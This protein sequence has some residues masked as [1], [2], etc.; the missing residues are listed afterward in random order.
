[1][2]HSLPIPELRA[3]LAL[4]RL[5]DTGSARVR[6]L[7]ARHGS[8]QAAAAMLRVA[9]REAR[10]D[11]DLRWL[12]AERHHLLPFTSADY[13]PLL[14][15]VADAPALLYVRGDPA[16]LWRAQVAVVG[17]RAASA[18]GVANA[19]KFAAA[20]SNAGITVTS[21][22]ATGIDGAAHSAALDAGGNTIAVCGTGLDVVYPRRH[23]ELA[24]RIAERDALVSELP[25]G[26]P[27]RPDHFPRRNRIISGLSLGTLVVE[28]NFESG[29][30]ITARLAA[31][32][33]REVFAIPGSIH[34]P[35]SRGCHRLLRQGAVLVESIDDVLAELGS[36]ARAL[37]DDIAARLHAAG[38]LAAPT[39]G[40]RAAR[41]PGSAP[42]PPRDEV[43]LLR[44]LGHDPLSVDEIVTRSGLTAA[45]VSSMLTLLELDGVV[46]AQAG[47][48]Y[49]RLAR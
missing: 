37:G 25:L 6:A 45:T 21:G 7:V 33:G 29:S 20:L 39:P 28:A 22:L 4:S 1:M 17:S 19:R 18:G 42:P 27:A 49:V 26:T 24:G 34:A 36:L 9:C 11:E 14:A 31:E 43:R 30:L 41:D 23:V 46:A 5:P 40:A 32:Q 2:P 8:A 44:A 38:A 16:L 3:W 10:V 47:A 35:D 13:P 15:H 48:R 12:E